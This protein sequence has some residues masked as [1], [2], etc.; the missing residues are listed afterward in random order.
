MEMNPNLNKSIRKMMDSRHMSS[1]P[2]YVKTG[3]DMAN[4]F[5][6]MS[7][8]DKVDYAGFF[9]IDDKVY[10]LCYETCETCRGEGNA[11]NHNCITC[12]LGYIFI[13]DSGNNLCKKECF[14][15]YYYIYPLGYYECTSTN[16]CPE[17]APYFVPGKRKCVRSCLEESIPK[18]LEY[19]LT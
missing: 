9:D 1:I 12:A 13:N 14:Y 11:Y 16:S 8:N 4:S 10:K 19:T 7:Q 17:G 2:E 15:A 3:I 5:G 18:N 6:F